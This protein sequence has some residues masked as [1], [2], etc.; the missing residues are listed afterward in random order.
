MI[1]GARDGN[2][3]RWINHGCEP[4]CVAEIHVDIDGDE[5]RDRVWIETLRDVRA[6]EE[7]TFDYAIELREPVDAQAERAWA[8]RCGSRACRG[9]MLAPRQRR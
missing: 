9:T 2:S 5:R 3:A 7:L 6:G 8:C 4:N 1:D